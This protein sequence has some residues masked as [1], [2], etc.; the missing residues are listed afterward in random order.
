MANAIA[1]VD[2]GVIVVVVVGLYIGTVGGG[3]GG[4]GDDGWFTFYVPVI[5]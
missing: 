5:A 4:S 2:D 3:V 1:A